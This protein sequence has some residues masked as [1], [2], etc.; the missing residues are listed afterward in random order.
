MTTPNPKIQEVLVSSASAASVND[1]GSLFN[2]ILESCTEYAIIAMDLD[3]KIIAW[4]EGAR[5]LLQSEAN[6]ML[7]K[8]SLLNICNPEE[9]SADKIQEILEIVKN[10][11]IWSGE[12]KCVRK[13]NND[14]LSVFTT[15]TTRAHA[16]GKLIGYTIMFA[17]QTKLNK[18]IQEL[19][20]SNEYTRSL[21]ESNLDVLVTTDSLGLIN[22]VNRQICEMTELS[23][24]ELIG[25]PFKVHFTDPKRAEDLIRKVL[26]ENRITNYE[27]IT[28]S[29]SAKVTS[30]SFNA[31][32]FRSANG[33]LKGIFATARNITEQKRLEEKSHKQSAALL[34]ATTLLND[35]LKSSIAYSIIALDL[36]GNI[37]VWNE[38]AIRNYGYT[39]E[40]MVGKQKIWILN[41]TE[42]LQSGRAK[43]MLDETLKM[44]KFDGVFEHVR[45]NGHRFPGLL[46]VTVRKDAGDKPVGF[47]LI[48]KD[49]TVQKQQEQAL[50]EQL[51]YNRSL[52]DSSIDVL[53]ATDTLGIITDVNKQM[54]LVTGYNPE[55]LIG[56]EFK[57]YFTDPKRAEDC[58][59]NVLTDEKVKNYELTI[60]AKNGKETVI[61]CNATTFK[62]T[63][64]NLRGVFAVARDITEQKRLEVESQD[65]NSKLKEATGFLN[66]VLESSTAY[67]II[68]ED[69]EGNIL[70]WNEGARLNYGY[71]A[72]EMVGKQN[73]RILH[74]PEDIKS[75]AYR[76]YWMQRLKLVKKKGY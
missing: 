2:S 29:Q 26:S 68:A 25:S 51:S 56:T 5:R 32:T 72:E 18:K 53:M 76:R 21:I 9:M 74:A 45:K 49:I 12:L 23:R 47:V 46:T 11:G 52:F 10:K 60:K 50:R 20:E 73:T 22:D 19:S 59:R 17:D 36:E 61:S 15:I 75:G 62:G 67:S 3:L 13:N 44:G 58:I 34:E 39:A 27:L 35:V 57:N 40:E 66:N 16:N 1:D 69:L 8:N 37:L 65:Q 64:Q 4:N 31:T 54:C 42:D 24:E 71:T 6:E 48:G 41:T 30:V 63:D 14:F 55:E 70:A 33:R 28:K 7:G 43:G 38:G